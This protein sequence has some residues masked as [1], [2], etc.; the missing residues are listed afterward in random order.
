MGAQRGRDPRFHEGIVA[1][2][3]FGSDTIHRMHVLM[4]GFVEVV[5]N[6]E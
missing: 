4:H 6:D 5:D 2:W 3:P 1:Q